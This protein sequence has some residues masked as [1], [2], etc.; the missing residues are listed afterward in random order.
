M[1][2]A[3]SKQ[4]ANP[5]T[6]EQI[7]DM[8]Y[9]DARCKL[10]DIAAFLDRV[11]RSAGRDDFRIKSFRKAIDEITGKKRERAKRVLVSLSD[12]TSK[13]I[14][15]APGKGACGAWPGSNS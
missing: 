10:I 13:P 2:A 9:M 15:E 6:R 4:N 12:P 14:A 8:Y 3:M 5:M 7:L 1:V 11:E